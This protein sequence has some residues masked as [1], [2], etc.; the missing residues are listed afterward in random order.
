MPVTTEVFMSE[1]KF[2]KKKNGHGY[3][4]SIFYFCQKSFEKTSNC[5]GKYPILL[6]GVGGKIKSFVFCVGSLWCRGGTE[7]KAL[8]FLGQ[9]C[10][11][12]KKWT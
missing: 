2:T 9:N 5:L 1:F 6:Q 12:I 10:P 8:M 3:S 11:K 7:K 4:M